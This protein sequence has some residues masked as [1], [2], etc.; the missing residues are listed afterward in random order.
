MDRSPLDRVRLSGD[1]FF[2][3]GRVRARKIQARI[4]SWNRRVAGSNTEPLERALMK[5]ARRH[6]P[7]TLDELAAMAEGASVPLDDLFRLNVTE[8]LYFQEK[9]TT[10]IM[11]VGDAILVGHN[12]DWDPK[13]N[14]VFILEAR[15]PEVSFAVI[16]YDGFLPGM[17]S[18]MNS[19][20]L[21]HAVNYLPGKA[22]TTGLPRTF[23]T[24]ALV[25]ARSIKDAAS[26]LKKMPH[27][28]GQS[29]NLAQGDRYRGIE[30][31][32]STRTKV[33]S[34][35]TNHY[36]RDEGN[37]SSRSRLL[38][39]RRLLDEGAAAVEI[40]SDRA[41]HPYAI[42]RNADTPE[43]SAATVATTLFRT[44][45]LEMKVWRDRPATSRGIVVKLRS[46][47][48]I[49]WKQRASEMVR[50]DEAFADA[51]LSA[52]LSEERAMQVLS[53]VEAAAMA[54]AEKLRSQPKL[55]EKI[56]KIKKAALEAL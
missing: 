15:M 27:A 46:M 50:E 20:G 47:E 42:W 34:V 45:R 26:A 48:K 51:L 22:K 39:A 3:L 53:E 7:A 13:R 31:G 43:D 5:T 21:V 17:S 10:V 44:D 29:I 12:E 8:L 52:G 6:A 33:P 14:D 36:L 56:R 23:V 49:D 9:C 18:G 2:E 55:A 4:E 32:E 24:R 41:T 25:T 28:V 30:I 1:I 19:H 37:A 11:P 38:R 16:G 54:A 40:L 35:H